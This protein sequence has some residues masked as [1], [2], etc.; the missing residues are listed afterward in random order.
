M[1]PR[2]PLEAAIPREIGA[3]PARMSTRSTRVARQL[4]AVARAFA[5]AG[6]GPRVSTLL[7]AS[8]TEVDPARNRRRMAGYRGGICANLAHER[9]HMRLFSRLPDGRPAATSGANHARQR[10]FSPVDA[11]L[12]QTYPWARCG[13]I[14]ADD[15]QDADG[16]QRGRAAPRHNRDPDASTIA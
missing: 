6:G 5:A 13:R 4:H 9:G 15:G 11:E 7:C 14:Q 8:V 10:W 3:D 16:R 1:P 2:S 12:Q